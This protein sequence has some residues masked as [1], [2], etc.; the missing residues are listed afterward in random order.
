MQTGSRRCGGRLLLFVWLGSDNSKGQPTE[1]KKGLRALGRLVSKNGGPGY[2]D[3]WTLEIEIP[4]ILSRSIDQH[5]LLDSEPAA[6]S[7]FSMRLYL[8]FPRRVSKLCSKSAPRSHGKTFP[9]YCIR[10]RKWILDLNRI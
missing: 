2:N 9:Q 3:D 5:D 6:Y 1:W 7:D 4:I 10:S 8:A